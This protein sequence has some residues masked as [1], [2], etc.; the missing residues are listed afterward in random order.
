MNDGIDTEPCKRLIEPV[1]EHEV[2]AGM[3]GNE[4]FQNVRGTYRLH[5]QWRSGIRR[6]GLF[7]M[8]RAMQLPWDLIE[9]VAQHSSN[10]D[11]EHR[12]KQQP[13][14]RGEQHAAYHAGADLVPR[15]GTGAGRRHERNDA[16][17]EGQRRHQD[18][19]EAQ[20]R[21]FEYGVAERLALRLPGD[22]KLHDENRVLRRQP[23][24]RD[25][26]DL[27]VDVVGHVED[28]AECRHA[29]Q[30]ERNG[31]Q[32]RNRYGPALV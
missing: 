20:Y 8:A 9:L 16:D 3:S 19:A 4:R 32:Y 28:T 14:E 22:G 24:H 15:S 6:F 5:C 2:L 23:D 29:E 10:R 12:N 17:D 26:A 25:H 7:W 31:Q 30:S 21:S 18:R 1:K 11:V 13:E 27:E